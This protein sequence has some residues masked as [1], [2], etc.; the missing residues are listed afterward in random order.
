LEKQSFLFGSSSL[1][2]WLA[3]GAGMV[4]AV[5]RRPLFLLLLLQEDCAAFLEEGNELV[6]AGAGALGS[7]R[8]ILI[9]V[10]VSS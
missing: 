7:S 8:F 1:P 6:G 5:D 2:G 10:R 3:G 4:E 9:R